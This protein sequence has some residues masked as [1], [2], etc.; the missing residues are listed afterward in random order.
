MAD[1]IPTGGRGQTASSLQEPFTSSTSTSLQVGPLDSGMHDNIRQQL[2]E[3]EN[4]RPTYSNHLENLRENGNFGLLE[5]KKSPKAINTH[6]EITPN[7]VPLPS[8]AENARM[9]NLPIRQGVH[10]KMSSDDTSPGTPGPVP[11]SHVTEL[12]DSPTKEI[13]IDVSPS[14]I[15]HDNINSKDSALSDFASHHFASSPH[16]S[17][18]SS[19]PSQP[20]SHITPLGPNLTPA[21]SED[22]GTA[23][24]CP[25]VPRAQTHAESQPRSLEQP[26]SSTPETVEH[27]FKMPL[28]T[29]SLRIKETPNHESGPSA[30]IRALHPHSAQNQRQHQLHHRR[31]ATDADAAETRA[32]GLRLAAEQARLAALRRAGMGGRKCV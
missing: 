20:V 15:V 27:C 26:A 7:E 29:D 25:S 19:Q 18:P 32:R 21:P 13:R 4:Q 8:M 24:A 1:P 16:S 12:S 30:S 11:L 2:M 6:T 14:S 22:P 17:F 10:M 31:T 9:E 5:P 3:S 28:E 23:I